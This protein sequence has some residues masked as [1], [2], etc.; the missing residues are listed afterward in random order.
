MRPPSEPAEHRITRRG[1]MLLGLQA[2]VIGTLAW[3]MHDLQIVQNEHYHLL[4][5]ENRVSIRLIPPARGL[6]LDREGRILAENRQN[7]RVVMIREQAR[8]PEAVLD[9]LGAIIEL[10]EGARERAL[11]EMRSTAAFVPVVV[12]EFLSWDDVVRVT[13]NAPV[14]PGCVPEVGLSRHYPHGGDTAHV[15]GYVGPVSERDL[16]ALERPDPLLRIPR[17]QIGK[18]GVEQRLEDALRGRAG[19]MRLETSAAGRVMR[20]LGRVEGVPG[21]EVTLTLDLG[22]QRYAMQRMEGESAATVVMD[23]TNGDLV[24][25]AAAP[26]FDPN[27]FVFGI[28][29]GEWTALLNDEYRPL[30]NKTVSGTYPPGSTFKMVVALAALEAGL[31]RPG[32]T[33]SCAGYTN[34]GGHRFHCWRRGGH[35]RVDLRRSISQSCDIYYYEMARRVGPDAIAAMARRLGLG[36]RH[37]LPLTAIAEGNMPT[38][39]WKRAARGEGW[40]TGD[41]YNYGIGQGFSSASPLQLAVMSARLATGTGVKPRLVRAIGGE[42]VPV[43]PPEDLGLDPD[44]LRRVQD[45]MY[46]V[47]NDGGTA[48]RSRIADPDNLIAGKTGTS[49]VRRITAAERAAGIRSTAQL[50]WHL[51]NHA[52]FVAYAPYRAPRYA[53]A[54][55][56]EHGGGGGAAAAP[57]ARDVMIR[58]LYG[59]DPP[60]SAWPPEQRQDVERR[61]ALHPEIGA[62]GPR[63]TESGPT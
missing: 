56:V 47:S 19:T 2:G 57:I 32:D 43:E 41:S 49:Q 34:L 3:R 9:R 37:D 62:E 15:V 26:G 20:E 21:A 27:S 29:T 36:V 23:V 46:A 14:L 53:V 55:V 22:V 58:A 33:V 8:D 12:A 54:T 52:L 28:S 51:R 6:I 5:E 45:G 24:A 35:G 31:M 18:N 39:E 48:V 63:P 16:A 1:L 25:C 50:P 40:T 10:P 59:P 11:R 61:R 7:Y 13:A 60:L 44:W 38:R 17:F 4:A 30:N 42:P